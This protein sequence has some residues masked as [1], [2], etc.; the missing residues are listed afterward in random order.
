MFIKKK[1]FLIGFL[2]VLK[3][4]KFVITSVPILYFGILKLFMELAT[5]PY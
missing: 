5:V 1:P 4:I 2:K 3:E